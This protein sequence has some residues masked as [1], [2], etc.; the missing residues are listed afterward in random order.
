MVAQAFSVN[1]IVFL[2]SIVL[3]R[4]LTHDIKYQYIRAEYKK[5][6]NLFVPVTCNIYCCGNRLDGLLRIA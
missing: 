1:E 5:S 6:G 4:R 3:N 2:K